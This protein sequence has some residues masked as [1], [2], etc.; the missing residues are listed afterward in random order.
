MISTITQPSKQEI[1]K[2]LQSQSNPYIEVIE[3]IDRSYKANLNKRFDTNIS[4]GPFSIIIV[5]AR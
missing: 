5:R 3:V 1:I 4:K 2:N